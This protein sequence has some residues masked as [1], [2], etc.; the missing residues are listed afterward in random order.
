MNNKRIQYE[1]E[2]VALY[3][4]S[5]E[6]VLATIS[7]KFE[8]YPF[9]SFI[10]YVPATSR[11]VIFYASN[12]A[13]HT[14]NL[15]EDPKACLTVFKLDNEYDKQNSARLTLMGDLK[16]VDES[17]VETTQE[18]FIKFLPESAKYSTMHDFNFYKLHITQ[19]RW[20]GGFGQIAW[21][22]PEPWKDFSPKW[23]KGEESIIDHMNDDHLN[24]VISALNAQHGIKD[25]KARM[26]SL[27]SDGY[28]I[29]AR[30]KIYFIQFDRSCSTPKEYRE[31]LIELANSYREFEIT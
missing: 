22:D 2:A 20:I 3:R 31:R 8:G 9:G 23:Q 24:T 17:E 4:S 13:Q 15:K 10:T 28:Y 30:D 29:K 1:K 12:I 18:R 5:N 25:K 7:K 26:I 21:L 19:V 27:S 11:T 6:A 16:A 14:I